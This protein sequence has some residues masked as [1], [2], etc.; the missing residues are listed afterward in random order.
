MSCGSSSSTTPAREL[1]LD[2]PQA[3]RGP[4]AS[5][6]LYA[7][8]NPDDAQLTE[9]VD[10]LSIRDPDFR[11]WWA[12]Y[13]VHRHSYGAHRFHHPVV[14]ELTLNYEALAHNAD[15]EQLLGLH[16]AEP[17]SRSE[18]ALHLLAS[19]AATPSTV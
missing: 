7:G 10:E 2:W 13:D 8:R 9:L 1:Y 17:G 16:T 3:A 6:H 11:R 5:L 14:G 18:Q 19:Y 15:P 12:D 4:V